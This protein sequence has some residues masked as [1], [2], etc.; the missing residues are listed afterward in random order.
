MTDCWRHPKVLATCLTDS[1]G[2]TLTISKSCETGRAGSVNKGLPFNSWPE[3]Q[4]AQDGFQRPYPKEQWLLLNKTLRLSL[5]CRSCVHAQ[6]S[7]SLERR[8]TAPCPCDL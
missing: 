3:T 7:P 1:S 4:V 5:L 8:R 2:T 6:P